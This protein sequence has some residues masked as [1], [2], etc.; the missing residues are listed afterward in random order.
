MLHLLAFPPS[1]T[2]L[3]AQLN[4]LLNH[5]DAIVLI[6]EGLVWLESPDQLIASANHATV[7]WYAL[8]GDNSSLAGKTVDAGKTLASGEK[9]EP[10][11]H[12][13]LVALSE[14]HHAC[15]SWY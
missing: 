3:L 13:G 9:I 4:A 11:D 6:D 5:G 7:H 1:R 8:A 2:D 12:H 10:L 14:I 15:A